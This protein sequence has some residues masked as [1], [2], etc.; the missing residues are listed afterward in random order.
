MFHRDDIEYNDFGNEGISLLSKGFWPNLK[1][2]NLSKFINIKA[3]ICSVFKLFN[4]WHSLIG[5]NN[6]KIYVYVMKG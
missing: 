2:L 1:I 4:Y 6:S 5:V 3:Q